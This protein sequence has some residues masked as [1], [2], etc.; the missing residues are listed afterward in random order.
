[1]SPVTVYV[2]FAPTARSAALAMLPVPND[3]AHA[4]PGPAAH[5]HATLTSSGGIVSSIAAPTTAEGPAF[6]AMIV[7]MI[8][9]PGSAPVSPSVFEID[10]SALGI[11]VFESVAELSA[12]DNSVTP[13]GAAMVAV[14]MSSPVAPGSMLATIVIV[15]VPPTGTSLSTLTSPVPE[16]VPQP[17]PVAATHV[18]VAPVS[19][20]GSV[21]P[22]VAPTT[23]EGP[24]L[25][26]VIV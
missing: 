6:D 1:M 24:T 2:T 5:V 16:A 22:I 3:D 14:F 13:T 20:A 15:T 26:A 12:G 8:V 18:Q 21:S 10:R 4:A 23:F 9:S 25:V 11:N 19:A 7:Y 17:A